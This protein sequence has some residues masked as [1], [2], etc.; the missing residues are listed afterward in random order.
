MDEF[1]SEQALFYSTDGGYKLK[2]KKND[3]GKVVEE[4]EFVGYG[5]AKWDVVRWECSKLGGRA[6]SR[7]RIP[8]QGVAEDLLTWQELYT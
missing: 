3:A 7:A 5:L 2:Q 1:G 6:E 8:V 4:Q